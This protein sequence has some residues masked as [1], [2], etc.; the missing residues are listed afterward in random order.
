MKK[1]SIAR[2]LVGIWKV[3]ECTT[4]YDWFCDAIV[5]DTNVTTLKVGLL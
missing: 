1:K 5:N 2:F 4:I 3:K